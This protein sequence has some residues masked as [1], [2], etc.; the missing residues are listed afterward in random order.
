MKQAEEYNNFDTRE[1]YMEHVT[2]Q[3]K[4]K[5]MR[6]VRLSKKNILKGT[7]I[8][9]DPGST[10]MGYAVYEH[11]ELMTSGTIT[12]KGRYPH[13]RLKE[14]GKELRLLPPA[15]ILVTEYIHHPNKKTVPSSYSKLLKSIGCIVSNLSWD[16]CIE[17]APTAWQSIMQDKFVKGTDEQDAIWIGE[18]IVRMARGE[19]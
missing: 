7:M 13:Q 6:M 14:L 17:I 12:V 3:N 19:T 15:D 1:E 11:G 16:Y 4:A 8:C 5:T 10:N 2:A 9:I 18:A